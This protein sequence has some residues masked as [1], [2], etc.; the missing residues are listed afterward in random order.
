M[1]KE[2]KESTEATDF[3]LAIGGPLYQLYLRARLARPPLELVHR[4]IILFLAICWLP[5]LVFTLLSGKALGGVHVPFLK[6]IE[7]QFTF[8]ISIPLLFAADLLVHKRM[9]QTVHHFR[10]Q[11]IIADDHLPRFQ[12]AVA[13]ALRWRNSYVA[14]VL[15]LLLAFAL[16]RYLW[17]IH[18]ALEV[19]TWFMEP[20]P[21]R[22]I[23]LAGW[24]YAVVSLSLFRFLLLRWLFRLF[25][26]H[27]FLWQVSRIPLR[28]N[29]F[30][31]DLTGGLWFVGYSVFAFVP[32]LIAIT[33]VQVGEFANRI[34]YEG[35]S[36]L[37]F[38][39]EIAGFVA[40]Q[41]L[42]VL[43]SQTSSSSSR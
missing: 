16:G 30:H 12:A 41:L 11:G 36:L 15:L 19:P 32:V 5:L 24:W 29:S 26:W 22:R 9:Q 8:L 37:Q 31:P 7:T 42:I 6:D 28:L 40:F 1:K 4:R 25:I 38:K 13:T 39:F 34:L 3:S 14:E 33:A 20:I 23:H 17:R 2:F 43:I 10:S 27:R 21:N 35:A 18:V